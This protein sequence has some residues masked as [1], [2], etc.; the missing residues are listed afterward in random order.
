MEHHVVCVLDFMTL[1]KR[2]QAELTTVSVPWVPAR[3]GEAARL[4]NEI[5]LDEESDSAFGERAVSHYEWYLAAMDEVGADTGPIRELERRLRGGVAPQIA[6]TNC[7]LPPAAE[8]FARTTFDLAA[9]P[10]HVVA[11]AF[12]YGR[13]E[14]L[15]RLFTPIVERLRA[16]GVS[17]D[18]LV[19]YLDRHIEVDSGE[20]GPRAARLLETV[21][22]GDPEKEHE[23]ERAAARA[24]SARLALWSSVM[25]GV[26]A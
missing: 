7:G 19:G 25:D 16:E 5:V 13:E 10:L 2:M 23:A 4:I 22:Q 15:P 18:L 3:N 6:L 12:F 1:L 20:H 17:C 14:V 9:K 11:A 24:L 21:C 26:P 8:E